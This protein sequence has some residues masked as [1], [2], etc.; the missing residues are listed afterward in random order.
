MKRD[1]EICEIGGDGV[2]RDE[3]GTERADVENGELNM[4][5]AELDRELWHFFVFKPCEHGVG[6]R[7]INF[8][9]THI[10]LT[11]LLGVHTYWTI[12]GDY[13]IWVLQP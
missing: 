13:S 3:V 1:F 8:G 7:G 12:V 9:M 11:G 2:E 10:V 5:G 6:M 4:N